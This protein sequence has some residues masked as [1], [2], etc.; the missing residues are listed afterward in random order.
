MTRT[1][2]Q[3]NDMTHVMLAISDVFHMALQVLL[4]AGLS[5]EQAEP[6]AR[7]MTADGMSA[8]PMVST[9]CLDVSKQ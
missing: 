4:D 8:S 9:D 1:A 5:P 6:V 2:A 7:V 3:N